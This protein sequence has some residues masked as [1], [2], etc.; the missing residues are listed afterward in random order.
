MEDEILFNPVLNVPIWCKAWGRDFFVYKKMHL[1]S[2]LTRCQWTPVVCKGAVCFVTVSIYQRVFFTGDGRSNRYSKDM[3]AFV[4]TG[5]LM[6]VD[7]KFKLG[8]QEVFL[9]NINEEEGKK[10]FWISLLLTGENALG[11]GGN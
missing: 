2:N 11:I 8:K 5:E 3:V 9:E 10:V 1:T 7:V 6:K 4:T